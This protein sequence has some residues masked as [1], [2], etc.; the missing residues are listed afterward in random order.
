LISG[1]CFVYSGVCILIVECSHATPVS[2]TWRWADVTTSD[3][4]AHD[5][6]NGPSKNYSSLNSVA[7]TILVRCREKI[8]R[9]NVLR[10]SRIHILLVLPT[11]ESNLSMNNCSVRLAS[12]T[13]QM[14]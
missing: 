3:A 2:T 4:W 5:A 14:S 13:T 12:T 6:T 9:K 7:R 11:A 1:V 8:V 10:S